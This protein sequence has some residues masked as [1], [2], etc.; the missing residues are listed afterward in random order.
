MPFG[1]IVPVP[2]AFIFILV[3]VPPEANVKLPAIF[4]VVPAGVHVLPVKSRFSNQLLPPIV[5][6]DAPDVNDKFG[7]VVTEPPAVLPDWNV[8]VTDMA[9]VNPPVP[10]HEKLVKSAILKTVVTAVVCANIMLAGVTLP[11]AID[12]VF[13]FVELN[14]PVVKVNPSPKVNEPAVNV[15]VPVA[16]NA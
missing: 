14:M 7:A 16:V 6:I 8:L 13:V 11:K 3:Y 15:Y 2:T 5:G 10:V 9:E 4:K 1:V 12:L